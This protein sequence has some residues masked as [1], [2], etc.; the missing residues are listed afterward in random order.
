MPYSF[1]RNVLPHGLPDEFSFGATFRMQAKS[2]KEAWSIIYID[3]FREQP[4]FGVR[5]NGPDKQIEVY[6][7]N[8]NYELITLVFGGG[9][10]ADVSPIQQSDGL[11]LLTFPILT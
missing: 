10:V 4:Q 5:M 8:H 9:A 1:F 7:R 3:D 6:Y 11:L 2:L